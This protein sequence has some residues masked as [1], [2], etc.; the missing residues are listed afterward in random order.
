MATPS[1]KGDPRTPV[2]TG[3]PA[4]LPQ[5][6]SSSNSPGRRKRKIKGL[7]RRSVDWSKGLPGKL[8]S[9]LHSKDKGKIRGEMRSEKEREDN[10]WHKLV[11]VKGKK[12]S[13]PGFIPTLY[14]PLKKKKKT[15]KNI[16]QWTS[17]TS[18]GHNVEEPVVRLE[19][20]TA[21]SLSCV[22]RV[23]CS[24]SRCSSRVFTL[25]SY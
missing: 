20:L 12:K 9:E 24:R 25:L 3:T 5:P 6:S 22:L 19:M 16:Y 10:S 23:R 21:A 11:T 17:E 13:T 15:H 1:S 4:A 2:T 7:N 18:T 14:H 8:T